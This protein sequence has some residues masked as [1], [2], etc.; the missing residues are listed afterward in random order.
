MT[1]RERLQ[2]VHAALTGHLGA[3]DVAGMRMVRQAMDGWAGPK[4]GDVAPFRPRTISNGDEP[5]GAA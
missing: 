4:D 5:K 2:A 3:G 1:D